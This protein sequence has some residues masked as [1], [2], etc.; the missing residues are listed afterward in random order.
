MERWQGKVA[1]VTGAASGI[2]AAISQRLLD[3]N[4]QVVGLD[5]QIDRLLEKAKKRLELMENGKCGNLFYALKCDVADESD[6]AAAFEWIVEKL[7]TVH[8][9][10]NDVGV[11]SYTPIIESDRASL[12]RLLNINVLAMA[13]CTAEAVKLMRK[14]GGEGHIFNINSVLGHEIPETPLSDKKG[15][16]GYSLY[17]ACKHATVAMTHSIRREIKLTGAPIRITSISPGL[18]KTEISKHCEALKDLFDKIPALDPTD[19]ADALIYALG[20]RPEVQITEITVRR[21]GEP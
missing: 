2:G 16:N 9:L 4:V 19:I 12:E 10:V 8:V 17:P 21:T 6:V 18:V 1:V 13:S 5:I 14:N 7:G 15:A 3:E 11:I 20:T